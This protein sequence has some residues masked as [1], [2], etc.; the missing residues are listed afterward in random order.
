LLLFGGIVVIPLVAIIGG[1]LH[2]RRERLLTHQERLKALELGRELPDDAATARMKVAWG[3]ASKDRKTDLKDEN[4]TSSAALSRKAFSTALWVAFWGFLAASQGPTLGH[5]PASM[6]VAIAIAAATGAI[7]VTV[8]ICGTI[9]ALRPP[10]V[11]D[12]T[13]VDK[14]FLESDALDVVSRRG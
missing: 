14:R 9:L 10:G 11:P 8:A 7:G 2:Y 3:V 1:F 6:A 12:A 4:E 5:S 13:V